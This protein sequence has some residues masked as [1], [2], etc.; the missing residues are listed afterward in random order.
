M[1]KKDL[2]KNV[3]ELSGLSVVDSTKAVTA[4]MDT[5]A[6]TLKKGDDVNLV[7]FLKLTKK[8]REARVGRNPKTGDKI[9]IPSAW[10]V[11]V[12]IGKILKDIIN[13]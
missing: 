9:E 2:V 12:T 7:G 11:K 3:A 5:I 1:N 6:D 10:V 4:L 8:K 13:S